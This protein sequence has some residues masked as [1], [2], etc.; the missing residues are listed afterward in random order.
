M[1]VFNWVRCLVRTLASVF[2]TATGFAVIGRDLSGAQVGVILAF[3]VGVSQG[4]CRKA[5]WFAALTRRLVRPAQDLQVSPTRKAISSRPYAKLMFSGLE[6][7]FVSAERI[8]HCKF[9]AAG[10]EDER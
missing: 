4:K 9:S 7:T 6:Q 3:A 2:V 5:D 1:P 10:A 8:N